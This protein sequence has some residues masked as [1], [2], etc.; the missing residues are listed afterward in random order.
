MSRAENAS[1]IFLLRFCC[2]EVADKN[3]PFPLVSRSS[4]GKEAKFGIM[5][6]NS[7][8]F[9]EKAVIGICYI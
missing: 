9:L 4:E 2:T 8:C 1:S 3:F 6:K 5:L 7:N